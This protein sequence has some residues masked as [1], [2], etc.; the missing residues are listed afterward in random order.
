MCQNFSAHNF[1]VIHVSWPHSYLL[2]PTGAFLH[3]R[4]RLY[5]DISKPVLLRTTKTTLFYPYSELQ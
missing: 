2:W 4:G 5:R 3:A 1:E